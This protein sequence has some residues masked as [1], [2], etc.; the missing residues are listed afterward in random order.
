M[1]RRIRGQGTERYNRTREPE[2]EDY[3][4]NDRRIRRNVQQREKALRRKK[5]KRS[6]RIGYILILIQ[7]L[8]SILFTGLL[9]YVNML[10]TLYLVLAIAVLVILIFLIFVTQVSRKMRLPGK[11]ISILLS[12]ALGFGSYYLAVTSGALAKITGGDI[13]T[14]KV[15]VIVLKDDPANSLSEVKD[16]PFGIC[17]TIDRKNTNKAIREIK[18]LTGTDISYTEEADYPTT[19][20]ALLNS[21]VKAII[22][23]E[24]Q[25]TAIEEQYPD[26]SKKTKVITTF[27]FESRVSDGKDINVAREPFIVY[28]SG[29]D[30]TG[31]V[32]S[33]G[34]TDVN[35]CAVVNPKT[36]QVLLVSTPRDAYIPLYDPEEEV[37]DGSLDKLTHSGNFGIDV[38]METLGHLYNTELDYYVTLNF[39]GFAKIVNALGGVEVDVE[40]GFTSWDGYEYKKGLQI[41]DGT[42]ALNYARERHAFPDGDLARNRHQTQVLKSIINKIL[43]PAILN[44]YT[45]LMDSVSDAFRTSLTSSEI[46]DLVKM[47]LSDEAEWN[48]VSF[49]TLGQSSKDYT[50]SI[51]SVPV[52]TVHLNGANVATAI[53]LIHGI[54]NGKKYTQD[55]IDEKKK[56]DEKNNAIPEGSSL[57]DT[58]YYGN[59]Q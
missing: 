38:S 33:T 6:R 2:Y 46:S 5:I 58:D 14:D 34:R 47:Q 8:I 4:Y 3:E 7:L 11:V 10:P 54:L 35:I 15:S 23:N 57:L 48:I 13:Q 9:V 25:R 27:T 36:K 59:G 52:D 51:S 55:A 53:D 50:Y 30:Q 39:T 42:Y 41:L 56:N 43:S 16:Y 12:V 17:K 1:S 19:A 49:N 45:K 26:F 24:G 31:E 29:N 28:L 18:K 20:E 21:S 44:N 37:P 22:F 32:A 40:S